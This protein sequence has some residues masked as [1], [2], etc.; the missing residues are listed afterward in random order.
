MSVITTAAMGTALF[1][2]AAVNAAERLSALR[3][4]LSRRCP[5]CARLRSALDSAREARMPAIDRA[6]E[7]P[8]LPRAELK[9]LAGLADWRAGASQGVLEMGAPLS[10]ALRGL[11]DVSDL[12]AARVLLAVLGHARYCADGAEDD[13]D[14]WGA[15]TDSLGVAA[16]DLG[17]LEVFCAR[18]ARRS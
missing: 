6:P 12:D 2:G 11:G 8:A 10:H 5:E 1:A 18:E 17:A 14:A 7:R 4:R 16:A 15:L 13:A 3:V 9:R